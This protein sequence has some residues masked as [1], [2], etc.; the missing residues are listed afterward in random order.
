MKR[1]TTAV[2]LVSALLLSWSGWTQQAQQTEWARDGQVALFVF[3]PAE[4]GVPAADEDQLALL[5]AAGDLTEPAP[6]IPGVTFHGDGSVLGTDGAADR[7]IQALRAKGELTVEAWLKPA[8]PDQSGPARI[9]SV[10]D[11]TDG[12]RRNL[13]LGQQGSRYILRLR[14]DAANSE[15]GYRVAERGTPDNAVLAQSQHV[16]VTYAGCPHCGAGVLR[17][18]VDGELL[19]EHRDLRGSFRTWGTEFPLLLGNEASLDRQWLGTL[20]LVAIYSRALSA[21]EIKSNSAIAARSSR[22]AP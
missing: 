3:A 1:T 22:S 15:G 7:I 16:A 13:T 18:F 17:F 12:Q 9:V 5:A 20:Y 10:S 19:A 8:S 2:P 14:T 6:Q 21:E 11:S 4:H